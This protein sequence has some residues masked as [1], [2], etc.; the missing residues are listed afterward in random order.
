[1]PYQTAN[2]RTILIFFL[3]IVIPSVF[4]QN[5]KIKEFQKGDFR[6]DLK[7]PWVNHLSLNPGEQF[8]ESRFGFVGEGLG[9]EYNYTN[10]KFLE[11]SFSFA[12]TS[13]I[14]LPVHVD[15]KYNKSLWTFYVSLTDNFIK[16]RFTVGYGINYADNRWIEWF[17]NFSTVDLPIERRTEFSNK[18]L[19]LNLNTYYRLGKTANVGI[20]YRPSLFNVEK[21]FD[22]LYEHLI[23]IEFMWR[24]SLFSIK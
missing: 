23:S 12:A 7:L 8:K 2:M 1:M 17:R 24:F 11:T 15:R 6:L 16:N 20:T 4:G 13:E 10:R 9:F 19:G 3:M 21:D 18:T 5:K 14:P 22:I